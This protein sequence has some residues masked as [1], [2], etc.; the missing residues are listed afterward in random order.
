MS[1]SIKLSDYFELRKPSYQYI[2]I[3]PHKSTR[4]F[5]SS[6][7]A[8]M[9]ANTYKSLNK[10]IYKEQKKLIFESYFKISYVIDIENNNSNFYFIVPKLYL[11]LLLEKIKEIWSKSTIE[12][13]KQGIKPFTNNAIQYELSYKKEDALSLAVDKKS[14]EPLNQILSIMQVM[15]DSDRVTLIYNFMPCSQLGWIDKYK[16]TMDKI[17]RKQSIEKQSMTFEYILKNMIKIICD[18]LDIVL[19]VIN[20]FLGGKPIDESESLYNSILGVL[21]QQ[22]ELSIATKKKKDLQVIDTQIIAISDGKDS[23]R[24]QNNISSISSAFRSIDQ[25]NELKYDKSKKV[26]NNLESYTFN[27]KVSKFSVDE[28]QNLIQIPGRALLTSLGIKHIKI[29]ESKVPEL[30]Q[31]G[32]KRLGI[33]KYK[34]NE[35]KA[36][37]EDTYDKASL[38]LVLIGAMGGGKSTYLANFTKDCVENNEGVVI[39]DFIKN[40]E[41][42]DNI[43]SIA[44]KEKI[45]EID[46]GKQENMQGFGFDELKVNPN[47][48]AFERLE[49]GNLQTT[50]LKS[51]IN[52]IVV[53]DPLSS[54]METILGAAG[55]VVFSLG[56][57]CIRDVMKCLTCH[58]TRAKYIE[59]LKRDKELYD[60]LDEEVET[61]EELN[62]WSKVSAQDSKKGI[63]SEVIGTRESK[64]EHILDR[65]RVLR[66]DAK[67]KY[68]YKKDTKNNVDFVKAM[69]E[70]KIII[71]KMPQSKFPSKHVKNILVTYFM[72]KI[73]LA[74]AT[75]GAL[76]DKPKPCNVI[77]DELF[78]APTVM[79]DLREIIPQTRK[80]GCK[81][82]FAT[83]NTKQLAEIHETLESSGTSYMLLTGALEDDFNHFKSKLEGFEYEDLRDMEQ[84][85]S[86]NL[87]YYSGGYSSFITKLPK[88]I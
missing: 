75:R 79:T 9:I 83:H 78:Q 68:M 7:I 44:P 72:S 32:K 82:V 39:I 8:K 20:D 42:S 80:F 45:L 13:C 6:N 23:I 26:I 30:L 1:K 33:A 48:T 55:D 87:I 69:E 35:T 34:G 29:E 27:T 3:I 88:P 71:I 31:H 5:N 76:H 74:C 62:E 56:Y 67:L 60:L 77:I 10:M 66:S 43:K 41:L 37:L 24:N 16:E 19:G 36:Y 65:T 15:K 38:P 81:L 50:Q 17:K 70:G 28:C 4:N 63:I 52:S 64:I 11:N 86:L 21:E 59:E 58:K 14:N 53:G 12:L 25:D 18:T 22:N 54:R 84:F 47:A 2:K 40:C 49:A 51:F 73:W 61:L 85:S 46:L 57:T